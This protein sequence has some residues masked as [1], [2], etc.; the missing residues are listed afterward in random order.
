MKQHP[1]SLLLAAICLGLT[2]CASHRQDISAPIKTPPPAPKA[3]GR[4]SL[5]NEELGFALI[6]TAETPEA[7]TPLQA[8]SQDGS[9]TALLKV[10]KEQKRPFVIAD[11]M[12]GKPHVGEVVTK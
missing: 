7:G 8:R 11:V 4:V 12:K 5:V 1:R 2:A 3:I 9:E 10:S 6:Q